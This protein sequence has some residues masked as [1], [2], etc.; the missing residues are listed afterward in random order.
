M[1]ATP[2]RSLNSSNASIHPGDN[3]HIR[4]SKNEETDTPSPSKP[5]DIDSCRTTQ[6]SRYVRENPLN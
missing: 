1:T 2:E 3:A 6:R 4:A 5:P